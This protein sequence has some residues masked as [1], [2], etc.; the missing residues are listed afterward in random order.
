MGV[1]SYASSVEVGD[2]IS[3]DFSG[4]GSI[5]HTVIV[6][7]LTSPGNYAT[8][9]ITQHTSDKFEEKTLK[10]LYDNGYKIYIYDI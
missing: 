6:T 8:A 10:N 7:R 2:P 3:I 1:K 9:Y 4:D 5:D